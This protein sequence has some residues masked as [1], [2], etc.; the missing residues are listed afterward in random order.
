MSKKTQYT[1]ITAVPQGISRETVLSTLHDHLEMIDL[2]PTHEERHMTKPPPEASPEEYH[3]QWY[4]ITDKISYLP[5]V[6]GKVNFKACFHDLPMGV[7]VHVYAPMGLD[8]KQKW[9]LAGNLPHEP[10]QPAEIGIGAPISGLYIRE[11]VEI[12]C[13]FLVTRFVRKTLTDGLATLVAR[14][15]VKSQLQ[16]AV[17]TNRRLTYDAMNM[18]QFVPPPSP[19]SSPPGSPPPS[20]PSMSLMSQMVQSAQPNSA[21]LYG[22]FSQD[23]ARTQG[24]DIKQQQRS[25]Y[26]T[27]QSTSLSPIPPYNPAA[28][29]GLSISEMDAPQ[30]NNQRRWSGANSGR[31]NQN[32]PSQFV[33]ELPGN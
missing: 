7:Q 5:G 33:A 22:S 2:N 25:S 9:T 4:Q 8:I 31:S 29:Q 32:H 13:N 6:G 3:C 11:D 20:S 30:N 17:Q 26:P 1:T 14:L 23:W 16:E 28:Y 24:M 10:A 19:G 15:V 27:P 18:G 21:P 12:K